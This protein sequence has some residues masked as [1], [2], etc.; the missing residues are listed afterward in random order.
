MECD[1]TEIA[2]SKAAA[3][4][5]RLHI[6]R[7]NWHRAC[8]Q[9]VSDAGGSAT[10]PTS[11]G[12][13]PTR[14]PSPPTQ[15]LNRGDTALCFI[16]GVVHPLERQRKHRVQLLGGE[17]LPGQPAGASNRRGFRRLLRK[18][19]GEQALLRQSSL[20]RDH[21]TGCGARPQDHPETWGRPLSRP[22]RT[23]APAQLS[24]RIDGRTVSDQ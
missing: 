10:W 23:G 16:A 22:D 19:S 14:F 6:S 7:A 1:R 17:R 12:F 18:G 15:R 20:Y 9:A 5:I 8:R 13:Q 4:I 3:V 2:A 24:S 21:R 11:W